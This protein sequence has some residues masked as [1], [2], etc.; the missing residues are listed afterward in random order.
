MRAMAALLAGLVWSGSAFAQ[1]Q[2]SNGLE[3]EL[4]SDWRERGLSQSEGRAALRLAGAWSPVDALVLDGSVTSLRGSARHGGSA[5]GFVLAPSLA[6]ETRGWRWR[7][8]V[9]ARAFSGRN[10]PGYGEVSGS[11]A[12]TIGPVDLAVEADYAPVQSAIG[13]DNLYLHGGFAA[14]LPGTRFTLL[15]GGGFSLGRVDNAARAA[16]LRPG[17]D[18][19]DGHLA[20]ERVSRAWTLG[21]RGTATLGA[22]N[23]Q[24]Q[25]DGARLVAYARFLAWP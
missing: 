1:A 20:I 22:S 6:G 2:S 23:G 12:R 14:A 25:R 11:L 16:R 9:A 18:Y 10:A 4:A 24:G 21:L 13:G 3:V 5:L 7:A 15:G 8:G 17:G 19:G